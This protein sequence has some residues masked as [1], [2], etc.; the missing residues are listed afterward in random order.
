[1]LFGEGWEGDETGFE[2][3]GTDAPVPNSCSAFG[4]DLRAD[5]IRSGYPAEER[6]ACEALR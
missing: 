5:K 1:V 3:T 2:L 6:W 4:F